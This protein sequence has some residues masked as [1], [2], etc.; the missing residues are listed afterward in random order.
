M[1]SPK[2]EK[3]K[4]YTNFPEELL[5]AIKDSFSEDFEPQT[6]DG[7]FLSFGR[8]YQSEIVLRLGYLQKDSITQINFDTT[9]EASGSEASIISAVENLVFSTKE[10][11]IDYFKHQDL[12]NFSYH[13]NPMNNSSKVSYK[14]DPSNTSLESQADA[15]LGD[16][17]EDSTSESLIVG[18]MSD[19]DEIERIIETLQTT[20]F[21]F[22]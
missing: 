3:N 6:K 18:D 2:N 12:N 10:L 13:W 19:S 11:F 8:I 20:N 9:I 21:T 1:I 17:P 4:A 22:K 14:L 7:S 5:N 15:L 16:I